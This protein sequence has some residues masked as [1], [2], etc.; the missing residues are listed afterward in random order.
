MANYVFIMAP[1]I[2]L[3]G[4]ATAFYGRFYDKVG[5]L[6]SILPAVLTLGLGCLILWA[7]RNTALVFLGSL[8]MMTGYLCGMAVFGAM[9]RDRTPVGKAGAFQGLRIVGQ[10]LVP[11][12]I[13]PMIGA[14]VLRNAKT[15]LGSDG[16]ESFVPNGS[17]FSTAFLVLIF[18]TVSILWARRIE[19]KQS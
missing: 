4:L 6:P 17:I 5:F 12:V 2:L 15:I 16:T 9:I 11:G 8:L 3:A 13:G 1:A 10:V 14:F 18:C 7:F 19:K